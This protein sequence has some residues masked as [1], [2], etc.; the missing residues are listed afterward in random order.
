M[1]Y[2]AIIFDMD[3]TI[4]DTEHIWIQAMQE[5]ITSRG[6]EYKAGANCPLQKQLRGL[7]INESCQIIKE[8]FNFKESVAELVQEKSKNAVGLYQKRVKFIDGFLDFHKIVLENNLKNGIATNADDE[9]VAITNKKLNLEKLFGKHIYGIS[10]VNNKCKPD[11]AIYL[12]AAQQLGIAP[13]ECIAVEDSEH[14]IRAARK[15]GMFCIGI[16]SSKNRDN[17]KESDFIIDSYQEL[18]LKKLL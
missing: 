16:N 15:A 1:N 11:P 4:I 2:K 8:T 9:T 17:V 3:G 18:D 6:I 7:A 12:Y 14:G 10:H 13:E 5:L